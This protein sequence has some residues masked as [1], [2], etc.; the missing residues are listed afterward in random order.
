MK[1]NTIYLCFIVSLFCFKDFIDL[2][3]RERERECMSEGGRAE[4]EGEGVSLQS[5][6]PDAVAPSRA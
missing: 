5:R 3:E 1:Y 6:E 4:G 2:L